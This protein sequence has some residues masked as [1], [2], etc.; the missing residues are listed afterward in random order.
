MH[1]LGDNIYQRSFVRE[2]EGPVYLIT[3]WPQI[4]CDLDNVY[5]VKPSVK[6]RTQRKNVYN[7]PDDTWHK[8]PIESA[9][10]IKYSGATLR[11]GSIIKSMQRCFK[12]SA[13][14]FDLPKYSNFAL[15][16]PYA[17]VRPV[18]VRSE[19]AN[20]ARNPLS[21][22]VWNA[23]KKLKASGYKTVS[24]ADLC[25]GEEWHHGVLP[26]CDIKF[27]NGELI[28]EDI[29]ALI[30]NASVV[31]GGVGWIVPAAIAYGTPLVTI[32]GGHG[33]HNAPEKIIDEPMNT[34]NV[35][36]IY[37]DSYCKCSNM[38][39]KCYKT[40]TNFEGK[41]EE[42]LESLCLKN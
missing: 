6:L 42:S 2:I 5:P 39:H 40:I 4:Y 3:S 8:A 19:W 31:I 37:P 7:Q 18:T 20:T 9:K 11:N 13:K 28:F 17:V 34:E 36:W 23:N 41:F 16:N 14:T 27:N 25:D 24:I 22:Y 38:L 29:M 32:L 15:D 26:E 30:Q 21:E 35:R 1:G 33:G 10:R 12:K